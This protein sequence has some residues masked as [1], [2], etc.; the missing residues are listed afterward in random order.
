MTLRVGL[1]GGIGS[2][3]STVAAIFEILGIP[4]YRSD[5]AAKRLMNEYIDL[6]TAVI[7]HYSNEVYKDG[8]LNRAFLATEVFANPSRLALLNSLV[9]P[10]TITD[11]DK[12]MAQQRA[13]YVL[14]E[15]AIIF[16][17]GTQRHLDFVIGV[18]APV[19][20]RIYRTMKRNNSNIEDVKLRIEQQMDDAIKMKLC[21]AVIVNDEQQALLPQ[22]MRL[23]ESLLQL[24]TSQY[25]TMQLT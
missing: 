14:K 7:E 21:D 2:G 3:K 4:V 17:T 10:A 13:P 9:H 24:A 20:L 18:Y 5:D 19:T 16:E 22:V 23:H 6:K 11:G 25:P 15:A 8:V 12:W 1:T